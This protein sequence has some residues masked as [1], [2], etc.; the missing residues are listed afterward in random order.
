MPLYRLS[1]GELE[2][3]LLGRQRRPA[4]V[5]CAVYRP[6]LTKLSTDFLQKHKLNDT[7]M[8][9]PRKP[10]QESRKTGPLSKSESP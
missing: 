7:F 10:G 8:T 3:E 1:V 9:S 6:H 2:G 4:L 5:V